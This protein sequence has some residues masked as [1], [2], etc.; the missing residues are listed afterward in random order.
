L[1]APRLSKRIRLYGC[2]AS[3]LALTPGELRAC[4]PRPGVDAQAF[5][6]AIGRPPYLLWG[7][8]IAAAALWLWL[9]FRAHP[10][11]G[12]RWGIALVPLALLQP[13]WWIPN[14]GDCGLLRDGAALLAAG[15]SVGLLGLTLWR[16]SGGRP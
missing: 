1:D 12:S 2:L 3:I 11:V 10:L 4:S 7:I 9:V 6:A 8:S 13:A 14:L 5:Y 15:M 16:G